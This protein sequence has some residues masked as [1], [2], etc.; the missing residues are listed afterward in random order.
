MGAVAPEEK[1]WLKNCVIKMVS[2]K[3]LL[4]F[5]LSIAVSQYNI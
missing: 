1:I 2:S 4:N 5:L 3:I